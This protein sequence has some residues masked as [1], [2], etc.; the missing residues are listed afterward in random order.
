[1]RH[2]AIPGL[3]MPALFPVSLAGIFLLLCVPSTF[4]SSDSALGS[5]LRQGE[6]AD[7]CLGHLAFFQFYL[8]SIAVPS[9]ANSHFVPLWP[10][11]PFTTSLGEETGRLTL[12][13][14]SFRWSGF[15]RLLLCWSRG[16]NVF[17]PACEC[18]CLAATHPLLLSVSTGAYLGQAL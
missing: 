13:L 18:L 11:L 12:G 9:L 4:T 16:G 8:R 3:R 6:I 14:R 10:H 15:P 17:I 5:I 2:C 1:M 7:A